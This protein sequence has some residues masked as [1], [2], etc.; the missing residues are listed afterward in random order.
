MRRGIAACSRE[1][2]IVMAIRGNAREILLVTQSVCAFQYFPM[3]LSS[4]PSET[5][6]Q[7]P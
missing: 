7:W 3:H 1:K 6:G 4:C 5:R 2:E